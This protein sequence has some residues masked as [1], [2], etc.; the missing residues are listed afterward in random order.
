MT[1]P[2]RWSLTAF[3]VIL[4]LSF[5]SAAGA[6]GL[7]DQ[8]AELDVRRTQLLAGPTKDET[9]STW[10][11]RTLAGQ[12][13]VSPPDRYLVQVDQGR[14][15]YSSTNN[16]ANKQNERCS[17]RNGQYAFE[18][19]KGKKSDVWLPSRIDIV[20]FEKPD[21]ELNY[22][23]T[24]GYKAAVETSLA[25]WTR[26]ML[27]Q[28]GVNRKEFDAREVEQI[29]GYK[30]VSTDQQGQVTTYRFTFGVGGAGG[31]A[32]CAV[33]FD[34][35]FYGLP[36]LVEQDHTLNGTATRFRYT[37]AWTKAGDGYSYKTIIDTSRSGQAVKPDNS[38]SVIENR[39]TLT[40]GNAIDPGSF[41]LSAFGLPEPAGVT[42][43]N[44]VRSLYV[45]LL[46]GG[47]LLAVTVYLVY[48]RRRS[49]RA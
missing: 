24:G 45:G 34:K 35:G 44:R 12:V 33:A 15:L 11:R 23:M 29:P 46:A 40:L 1:L 21:P 31:T 49:R 20:G 4:M 16:G 17:A 25:T 39:G 27:I 41:T 18:L 42:P 47:A 48:S 6:G 28:D 26:I 22:G 36:T 3:V 38:G 19:K 9:A 43:P 30:L 7:V 2:R 14:Y 37:V 5:P 13:V 8:A 10:S 32:T